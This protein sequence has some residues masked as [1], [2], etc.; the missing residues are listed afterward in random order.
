MF[1]CQLVYNSTAIR[2][3]A[4]DPENKVLRCVFASGKGYEYPGVNSEDFDTLRHAESIGSS[5]NCSYRKR[6]DYKCLSDSEVSAFLAE[7]ISRVPSD[8]VNV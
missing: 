3:L 1:K 4:H 7:I 8:L 5:F 6:Q 2:V